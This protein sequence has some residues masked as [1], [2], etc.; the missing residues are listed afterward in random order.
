MK[1]IPKKHHRPA[2]TTTTTSECIA[3]IFR[4]QRYISSQVHRIR[5]HEFCTVTVLL[6]SRHFFFFC[7]SH[8]L[9][10]ATHICDIRKQVCDACWTQRCS[11]QIVF[12]TEI[13]FM[14]HS[15][16]EYSVFN[17]FIRWNHQF[18]SFSNKSEK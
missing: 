4:D 10:T 16:R 12:A 13:Q 17:S 14:F 7:L 11:S 3:M 6:L 18:C 5:D 9:Y 1:F 15:C 2:P 8:C